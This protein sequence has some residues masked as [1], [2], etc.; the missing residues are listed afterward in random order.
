MTGCQTCTPILTVFA[1]G[2]D[3][4]YCTWFGK[5]CT[6][7]GKTCTPKVQSLHPESAELAPPIYRTVSTVSYRLPKSPQTHAERE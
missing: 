6:R 1:I 3:A 2:Q 5:K 4:R 7:F